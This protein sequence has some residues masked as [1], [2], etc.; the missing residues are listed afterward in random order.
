[1]A[2]PAQKNGLIVSFQERQAERINE[3]S[4][5]SGID[6][7]YLA[8]ESARFQQWLPSLNKGTNLDPS[9]YIGSR[10]VSG[11][12]R[13]HVA[14]TFPTPSCSGY[15][16]STLL[17]FAYQREYYIK[18]FDVLLSSEIK[19]RS[20]RIAAEAC[21]LLHVMFMDRPNWSGFKCGYYAQ[22][23]SLFYKDLYE[24]CFRGHSIDE[25]IRKLD[26][27]L[28]FSEITRAALKS[29]GYCFDRRSVR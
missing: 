14:Q 11:F 6:L 18:P 21:F 20:I 16:V 10:I 22:T 26:N 17:R 28:L 23:G 24:H 9:L 8:R 4:Q 27:F 3:I 15:I 5:Q 25:H 7:E 29:L 19:T 1:M 2:I 12:G 13:S